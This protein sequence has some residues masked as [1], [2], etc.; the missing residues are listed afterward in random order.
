MKFEEIL[1]SSLLQ[2]GEMIL[3]TPTHTVVVY[4]AQV[5]NTVRVFMDGALLEDQLENFKKIVLTRKQF[6]K[7]QMKT[8]SKCKGC[9]GQKK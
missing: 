9:R 1:D 8:K 5:E 4:A 6:K 2:P 7:H 3:H